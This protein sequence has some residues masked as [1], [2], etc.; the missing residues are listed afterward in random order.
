MDLEI[1]IQAIP[2]T[3]SCV[4]ANLEVIEYN[5]KTHIAYLG[6]PNCKMDFTNYMTE[7]EFR[8]V[9]NKRLIQNIIN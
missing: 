2:K 4:H 7:E 6:C 3:N 1:L 5:E 8:E 9:K